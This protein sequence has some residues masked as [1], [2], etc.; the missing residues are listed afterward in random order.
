MSASRTYPAPRETVFD[1]ILPAPLEQ[2]FVRRYGPIP[3]VRG[4]DGAP[5]GPWGQV[6]YVRTVRMADGAAVREELTRVDRPRAFGYTLSEVSGPMKFLASRVDGLWSF[7]PA[8]GG[9]QVTWEWIVHP[10]SAFA[11]PLLPVFALCWRQFAKR[12]LA[13]IDGLVPSG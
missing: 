3:A 5:Q 7:A 10:A 1:A 6:G 12:S 2:V 13:T 9:T 4:T 8:D 11:A